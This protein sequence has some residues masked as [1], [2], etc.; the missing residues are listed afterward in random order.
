MAVLDWIVF[1]L[2]KLLGKSSKYTLKDINLT[3]VFMSSLHA[4]NNMLKT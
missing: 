3:K 1:N 2:G 4:P